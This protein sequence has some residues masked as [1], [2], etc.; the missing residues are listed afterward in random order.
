MNLEHIGKLI[1]IGSIFLILLS[2]IKLVI[3]Y[4]LFNIQITDYLS[5]DEYLPLF[6]DDLISYL[7]SF[8]TGIIFIVYENKKLNNKKDKDF[9]Y[10]IFNKERWIGIGIL[11]IALIISFILVY[12][13]DNSQ[14]V[15]ANLKYSVGFVILALFNYFLYTKYNFSYTIMIASIVF[16]WIILDGFYNA[17]KIKLN[18][19]ENNY[20]ITFDTNTVITNDDLH[21]LGKSEKYFFLYS[22]ETKESMILPNENLKNIKIINKK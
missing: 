11:I 7:L 4:S 21:Y 22:L 12:R 2:S 14:Q 13:A 1:P 18:N 3:F 8:G 19:N 15:F 6:L 20:I 16:A 10:S 17:F 9:N 5:I